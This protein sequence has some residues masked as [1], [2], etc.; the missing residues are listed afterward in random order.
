M[1]RDTGRI[2]ISRI[3]CA[4]DSGL[5]ANP[6]TLR[7]AIERQLVYGIGRTMIEEAHFDHRPN[8]RYEVQIFVKLKAV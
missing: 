8:N 3:V 4:Q 1:H 5:V 7:A 2:D 6:D